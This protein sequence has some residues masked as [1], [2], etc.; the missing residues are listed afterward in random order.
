[1]EKEG[2]PDEPNHGRLD[3]PF[4]RDEVAAFHERQEDHRIGPAAAAIFYVLTDPSG[5]A[6]AVQIL[7]G[8]F[9]VAAAAIITFVEGIFK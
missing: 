2:L 4:G 6:G 8:W 7:F 9:K 3:S 5:A 1:V